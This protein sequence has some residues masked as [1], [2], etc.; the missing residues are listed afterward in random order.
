MRI[1]TILLCTLISINT[2]AQNYDFGK[3]SK[4]ELQEKFNPKDSSASATYLYKYRRTYFDYTE[5]KGF[6]L[7][8]EIHERIKI[9][10]QE[11]FNYAT[12]TIKLYKSN[13]EEENLSGLKAYT[14]N[15]NNGDIEKTKIDKS[16]IFDNE[17]SKFLDEKKFTMD[18]IKQGC[19]VEYK[20]KV[21]SP[22]VT[23]IDEFVFQNSIPIKK[24]KADFESPEYF[25]FKSNTKGY[26]FPK[27]Q[28]ESRNGQ[29]TS[30][31]KSRSGGLGGFN[32]STTQTSYSNFKMDYK[33]NADIYNLANI[34]ALKEEPYV[35]NI[36]NYR[37]AV[38]YE[39]SYIKFPSSPIKHYTSSWED[40]VKRIYDNSNFGGELEKKS[41]YKDDI[42]KIIESVSDPIKRTALIYNFVKSRVNWNGYYG[43][44]TDEGVKKA[45]KEQTGNVAD[46]NLMLTS[47]L[48]YAGVRAYPV[49]VSTRK[50]GVPLFPTREGFDYVITYVKT[51]D[52]AFLLDATTKFGSPN[53]LPLRALNWQGRI[54]TEHGNSTLIDLYSKTISKDIIEMM[55]TLD[56]N[57]TIRGKFRNTKTN[58]KALSFRKDFDRK[59]KDGFLDDLENKYGGMEISEFAVKH[60]S[61]LTKPIIESFTFEKENQADIIGDKIYFSPLFYMRMGENPFKLENREF[62]VDFGYPYETKYRFTISL[63]Q[64]YRVESLPESEAF[65]MENSLGVFSYNITSDDK[66]IRIVVSSKISSS[67]ITSQYYESLK[68]YF[69]MIVK[70]EADQVVLTKVL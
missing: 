13:N 54:I 67:I 52:T 51:Q 64:G 3:V 57:G 17:V 28:K 19:I 38:K 66:N 48:Q 60:Q 31:S 59:G 34:P 61:D 6:Q 30:I 25:N 43:Y 39:L 58:H 5:E 36:D 37:S 62:P 11:G 8:T 4:E 21:Y 10:N 22:F 18:N 40:V 47:M 29:I 12:K 9:Y 53:L 69:N 15:L 41:Y 26:L 33:K 65:K 56:G 50:N 68:S 20:Y 32:S 2:F 1:I 7:V 55:I 70:K 42:D 24:L 49:L 14:Y 46:I 27:P 23:N 63:P 44:Y 16:G 35:N 45:Y